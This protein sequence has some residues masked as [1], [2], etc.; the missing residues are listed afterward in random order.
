MYMLFESQALTTAT[1]E[2]QVNVVAWW[3]DFLLFDDFIWIYKVSP[4][5]HTT[6]YKLGEA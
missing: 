4:L 3:D 1:A 2:E 6:T 5:H